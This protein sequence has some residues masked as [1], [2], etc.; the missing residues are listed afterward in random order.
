M[1]RTLREAA[2]LGDDL[3]SL[4]ARQLV[5]PGK[6]ATFPTTQQGNDR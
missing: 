4:R 5:E 2:H 3:N 6:R 1:R